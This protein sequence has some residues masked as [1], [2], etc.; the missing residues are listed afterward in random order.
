MSVVLLDRYPRTRAR[1]SSEKAGIYTED[2][3]AKA[4]EEREIKGKG[5]MTTYLLKVRDFS[6]S[7]FTL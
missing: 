5:M 4:G 2:D 7:S 6:Q 1:S 3:F